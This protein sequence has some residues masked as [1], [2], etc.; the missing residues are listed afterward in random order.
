MTDA[1]TYL[2]I[3]AN[4]YGYQSDGEFL[5]TGG[6]LAT[7]D[8]WGTAGNVARIAIDV[9]NRLLWIGRVGS[10]QWNISGTA[11]PATGVGGISFNNLGTIFPA[12]SVFSSATPAAVQLN[13]GAS[14]YASA[15]P[16]GFGN[17][18]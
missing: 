18:T 13:F 4:G 5:F 3:D 2:G 9:T 10:G 17:W 16:S 11:N 12:V 15:A 1:S 7:Y 8:D 14:A 6:S